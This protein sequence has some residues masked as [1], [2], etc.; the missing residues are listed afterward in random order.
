MQVIA[1]EGLGMIG[2]A[3]FTEFNALKCILFLC[4]V[5]MVASM[6]LHLD[7]VFEYNC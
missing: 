4:Y 1:G 5:L 6:I 3:S 2:H 7:S